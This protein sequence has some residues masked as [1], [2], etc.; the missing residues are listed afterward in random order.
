MGVVSA[1]CA[2]HNLGFSLASF[3]ASHGALELPSI[4]IAG[5]AGLRLATG[6]LFPGYLSR[7]AALAEAGGEAVQLVAGTI[8]LLVVAGILEGFLSPTHA[9]AALKFSVCGTLLSLLVC[10][11]TLGGRD[12][13]PA[14]ARSSLAQAGA[15]AALEAARTRQVR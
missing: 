4:F 5:A 9:P 14:A 12:K 1:A 15:P 8:P 10:W 6:L 2:Q 13:P 7:K 11:L 3:V